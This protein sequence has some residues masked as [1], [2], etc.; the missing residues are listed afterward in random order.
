MNLSLKEL[1]DLYYCVGKMRWYS[2]GSKMI[3]NE[4]C[5][6]LLDKLRNEIDKIVKEDE[7]LNVGGQ[8]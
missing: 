1:N 3:S 6:L 7:S 2:E 8:K 4:E 5:E